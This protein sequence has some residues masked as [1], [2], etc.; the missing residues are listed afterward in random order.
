LEKKKSTKG[1]NTKGQIVAAATKLIAKVGFAELSVREVARICKISSATAF[2]H[3]P[4]KEL[5]VQE[6]IASV[7]LNNHQTVSSLIT[8]YDDALQKLV[9]HMQG[10]LLW[11]RKNPY[12][13]QILILLYYLSSSNENFHKIYSTLLVKARERIK[14]HLLAGKREK[15]FHFTESE[16]FLAEHL[17]NSLVGAFVNRTSVQDPSEIRLDEWE[18]YI[19]MMTKSNK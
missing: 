17:H 7:V 15:L 4:S 12:Q 9:K 2:Y 19:R 6:I 16:D 8:I 13:A 5:L 11:A 14:E 3:F 1:E 18:A 10:N